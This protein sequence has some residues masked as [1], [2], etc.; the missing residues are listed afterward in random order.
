MHFSVFFTLQMTWE[1]AFLGYVRQLPCH[2]QVVYIYAYIYVCVSAYICVYI[3]M[4]I[5]IDMCIFVY[6]S[7]NICIYIYMYE[8]YMYI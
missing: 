7:L 4:C 2:L 1:F 8:L 3:H 5:D 6:V